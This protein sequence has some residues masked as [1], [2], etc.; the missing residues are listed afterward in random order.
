MVKLDIR[1]SLEGRVTTR[2]A[3]PT[4]SSHSLILPHVVVCASNFK[5]HLKSVAILGALT[6][7]F[8]PCVGEQLC[9]RRSDDLFAHVFGHLASLPVF[10]RGSSAYLWRHRMARRLLVYCAGLFRGDKRMTNRN[11]GTSAFLVLVLIAC[12]MFLI[13]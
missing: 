10:H 2:Y 6:T 12:V 11:S 7:I 5:L 8:R 4:L 3:A 1:Y 13:I 9:V